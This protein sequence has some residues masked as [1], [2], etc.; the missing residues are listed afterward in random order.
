MPIVVGWTE[1]VAR[2]NRA[3]ATLTAAKQRGRRLLKEIRLRERRGRRAGASP[4]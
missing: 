2:A 3:S 1:A 4:W